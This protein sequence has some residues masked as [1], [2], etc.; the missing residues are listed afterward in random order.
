MIRANIGIII[1]DDV[2]IGPGVISMNDNTMAR[3]EPGGELPAPTVGRAARIGGGVLLTPGVKVGE[4]AFV[5]AGALV[6]RD[7][8]ARE[9]VFG[10]PARV[11]GEVGA[12]ELL[13]RWRPPPA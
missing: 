7:V 1:G 5:G 9:R 3:L 2:F 10:V 4:E 11:V 12:E 6:S 13:D 8:G